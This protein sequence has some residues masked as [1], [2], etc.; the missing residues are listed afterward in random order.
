VTGRQVQAGTAVVETGASG[1]AQGLTQAGGAGTG[2][3]VDLNTF[4]PAWTAQMREAIGK[5]WDHLQQETGWVEVLFV[6]DR[7]GTV[8]SRDIVATSGSF[9][10]GQ[11]AMRAVGMALIPPLPRDYTE[12][13]LRVRLRFNYEVK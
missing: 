13:T 11:V 2:G 8:V 10:L 6:V 3:V 9:N 5:Q 4:D 7:N 12:P 1:V